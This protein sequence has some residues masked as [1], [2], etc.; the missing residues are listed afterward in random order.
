M[1]EA[2]IPE[3]GLVNLSDIKSHNIFIPPLN[4]A[5]VQRQLY[6]C[7]EPTVLNFEFLQLLK[8]RTVVWL[9]AEDPKDAFLAFTDNNDISFEHL[10]ILAE[11][12]NPWDDITDYTIKAALEILL[13]KSRYPVMVCCGMGRH[14]TGTV[15]GCL[16]KLQ[17][18]SFASLVDEYGRFAGP[19]GERVSVEMK[20]EQFDTSVVQVFD[21]PEWYIKTTS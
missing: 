19:K 8:I 5:P 12:A 7:G 21:P 9:A 15:V 1:Q 18:W 6:R 10:G 13:D 14:R 2:E 4:F 3:T 20:I 16:R 11:G 17:G